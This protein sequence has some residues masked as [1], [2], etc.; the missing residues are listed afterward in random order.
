M[1]D[2]IVSD[3]D[4]AWYHAWDDGVVTAAVYFLL[5]IEKAEPYVLEG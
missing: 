2:R 1:I 3:Q 4:A 5:G